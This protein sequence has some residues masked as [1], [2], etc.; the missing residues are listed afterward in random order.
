MSLNCT[1]E[2]N[3]NPFTRKHSR[4]STLIPSHLNKHKYFHFTDTML[5][6]NT[7]RNKLFVQFTCQ[8]S[9]GLSNTAPCCKLNCK[10]STFYYINSVID[11]Y[12]K[13]KRTINESTTSGRAKYS[14]REFITRGKCFPW[15]L[16]FCRV[17]DPKSQ[18]F[19]PAFIK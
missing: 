17:N 2:H 9:Y 13:Y 12:I 6:S 3:V 10:Q 5:V 11:G 15:K 4:F 14:Q 1:T 18:L 8:F 16:D 7:T 19:I